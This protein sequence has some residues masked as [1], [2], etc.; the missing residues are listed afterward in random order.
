M[1]HDLGDCD[2]LKIGVEMFGIKS[3]LKMLKL[4]IISLDIKDRV[5]LYDHDCVCYCW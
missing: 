4:N 3:A 5:M 1:Y 2:V